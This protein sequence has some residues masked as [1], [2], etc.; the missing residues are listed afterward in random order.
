MDN[1]SEKKLNDT[2]YSDT[3]YY[4]EIDINFPLDVIF[5]NLDNISKINVGEKLTH[6]NKYI[7]VDNS[8]V[9]SISRRYYGV[10]RHT[11]LDFID[12]NLS[13]SYKHLSSLKRNSDETSGILWIKLIS[14]LKNSATGLVKLRQTYD[15]DEEFVKRLDTII[16]KLLKY[17]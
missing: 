11:I 16:K 15:T 4:E 2:I 5:T 14:R 13:E 17:T 3:S 9:K 10:S 12:K 8:Y 6:N 1:N 7:T